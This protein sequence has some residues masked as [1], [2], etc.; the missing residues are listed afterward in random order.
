MWETLAGQQHVGMQELD[1]PI[2]VTMYTTMCMLAIHLTSLSKCYIKHPCSVAQRSL[3][4]RRLGCEWQL[5]LLSCRR[6]RNSAV[7]GSRQQ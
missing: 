1:H 6:V 3:L 7:H 5:H 2:L 4:Q